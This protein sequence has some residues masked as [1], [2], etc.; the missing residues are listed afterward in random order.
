MF[1]V[2]GDMYGVLTHQCESHRSQDVRFNGIGTDGTLAIAQALKDDPEGA[3]QLLDLR[4]NRAG[5]DGCEG[6]AEA[7]RCNRTLAHLDLGVNAVGDEGA[8]ELA[9]S[10][11][12][13]DSLEYLGLG[14]NDVTVSDAATA[15][16][17]A[18]RAFT[19][20]RGSVLTDRFRWR[21][22]CGCSIA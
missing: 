17:A 12:D 20:A 22:D 21:R 15:T 1:C 13:N 6:L 2:L 8:W 11:E 18:T 9:D 5:V 10:L 3:L 16:D 19:V 7:L 14:G 4:G